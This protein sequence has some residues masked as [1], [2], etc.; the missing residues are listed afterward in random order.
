MSKAYDCICPCK[1]CKERK[2][3]CHASCEAYKEWKKNGIE[4]KNFFYDGKKKRR[5]K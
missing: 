3:G 5:R 4:I 1:G 2:V